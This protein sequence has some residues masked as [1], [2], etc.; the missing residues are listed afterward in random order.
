[1]RRRE[2]FAPAVPPL[3][4]TSY[5]AWC[6]SRGLVPFGIPADVVSLRAAYAQWVVWEEQRTAWAEANG[7]DEGDLDMDRSAPFDPDI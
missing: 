6:R 7:V 2:E 4:V 5:V 3:D 1:M